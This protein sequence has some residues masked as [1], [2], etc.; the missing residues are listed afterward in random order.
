MTDPSEG[1]SLRAKRH[2]VIASFATTG[3]ILLISLA[4]S[5]ILARSLGPDGRGL[6]LALTFW[7]ALLAA[8]F[9]LSM[10]EAIAYHVARHVGTPE[11]PRVTGA[12]LQLVLVIA[13]IAT[14]I[15][16]AALMVVVPSKY[17]GYLSVIMLYAAAFVPLNQLEQSVR[18]LLQGRGAML[19]LSAVRLLQ[20]LS[21]LLI[22]LACLQ[23]GMLDVT[24]AMGAVICSLAICLVGG[25]VVARPAIQR[26]DAQ[27]TKEITGTGWTFHKANILMYLASEID[28]AIVLIFLT[29]VQAG[30]FA[31]ALAVSAIGTGVVLQ[32]LGLMLMHEMATAKGVDGHRKVFLATM[33]AAFAV[34]LLVNGAVAAVSPWAIPLLFGRDF[35]SAVPVAILL[36]VMGVLKGGRQMVDKALRATRH[37]KTGMIGEATALTG[38]LVLGPIGAILGGLEGVA[39]GAVVAQAVALI[40]VLVLT[41]RRLVFRFVELWPFRARAIQE[42]RSFLSKPPQINP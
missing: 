29:T 28:K 7:P 36:L 17:Q 13:V 14:I 2:S 19:S 31:V 21:Y 1:Q 8:M 10:P 33:R 40:V 27:R 23:L 34:L 11:L 24:T 38:I 3:L 12:G 42:L 4:T 26:L 35:A 6:L 18:G 20:P 32:S 39:L 15:V 9:S 41:K 5:V 37:T 22:L 25:A 30:L 16:V